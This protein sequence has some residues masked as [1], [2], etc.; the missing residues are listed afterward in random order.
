MKL[1]KKKII[2]R[3]F[4]IFIVYALVFGLAFI[5]T[6]PYNYVIESRIDNLETTSQSLSDS[7]NKIQLH[8]SPKID[9]QKEFFETS[10]SKGWLT[11]NENYQEFWIRLQK[12]V[13]NDSLKYKWNKFSANFKDELKD[14]VGFETVSDF[15]N[16]IEN[17]SLTPKEVEQNTSAVK[18]IDERE[19]IESKI[20]TEKN[21]LMDFDDRLEFSL[22]CLM[23]IGVLS[24]PLRY[25]LY[26]I[27]WSIKTLKQKE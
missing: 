2:A 24:F 10:K 16:Y 11:A 23:I 15:E 13:N 8:F 14:E 6:I 17:N 5:S 7:I 4:L 20:R 25:L 21:K 9:K 26:A 1:N 18:L 12:S 22:V 3:E 27:K 19:T